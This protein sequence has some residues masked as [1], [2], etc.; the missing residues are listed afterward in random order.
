M[1][2]SA[3]SARV[4]VRRKSALFLMIAGL[5]GGEPVRF[6]QVDEFA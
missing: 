6:A 4:V 2:E 3:R 1:K 5:G